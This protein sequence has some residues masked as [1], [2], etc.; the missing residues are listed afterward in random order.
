[1]TS[2][3]AKSGDLQGKHLLGLKG[4]RLGTVRETYIDLRS[5]Q[6]AF[7]VVETPSLLGGS[8]K[9][10]PV[11]WSAVRYDGVAGAFVC[12]L[13]K[14]RFKAAPSYDRDQ[15]ANPVYGWPDQVTS[16]F[17]TPAA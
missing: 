10:Q 13:D 17:S 9:F 6:V 5:G 15:L 3:L 14:P 1:M 4:A 7:L 12:E 16:Y 11:P 8:G 2:D